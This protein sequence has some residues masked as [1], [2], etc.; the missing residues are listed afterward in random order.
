MPHYGFCNLP[1][2]HKNSYQY[3][4][5]VNAIENGVWIGPDPQ[6]E[7]ESQWGGWPAFYQVRY[8]TECVSLTQAPPPPFPPPNTGHYPRFHLLLC[9]SV[10][11]PPY[12]TGHQCAVQWAGGLRLLPQGSR[13][14]TRQH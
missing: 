5:L 9:L 1:L 14:H 11:Q 6:L 7:N 3:L 4:N 10:N 2:I 13:K 12:H 8:F